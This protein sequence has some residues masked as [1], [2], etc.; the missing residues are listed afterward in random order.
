M[1]DAVILHGRGIKGS[2][3]AEHFRL[4]LDATQIPF[5]EDRPLLIEV[6]FKGGR[7]LKH[8]GHVRD[9]TDI[10]SL[11]ILLKHGGIL[12]HGSHISNLGDIPI[13]NGAIEVSREGKHVRHVRD[14]LGIPQ[15]EGLM[16]GMGT[17]KHVR[18][19]LH[20]MD[21]PPVQGLIKGFGDSEHARH[22]GD[23]GDIP[24]FQRRIEG[25]GTI[26][27]GRHILHA[28]DVPTAQILIELKGRM[29]HARQRRGLADIPATN[30]GIE[31]SIVG[32]GMR[33]VGDFGHAPRANGP[34]VRMS[35]V[36]VSRGIVHVLGHG[37]MQFVG[38][39]EA[40]L[41]GPA[42]IL[43]IQLQMH[44]GFVVSD[45]PRGVIIAFHTILAQQYALSTTTGF[46]L[47]FFTALQG[48]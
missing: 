5:L 35:N 31:L 21:F 10:P 1:S 30:V 7:I 38:I 28:S 36:G 48:L 18:H 41:T 40:S 11:Q 23:A 4:I 46:L 47:F 2:G 17:I 26:E 45:T 27:Q 24:G 6:G 3:K 20:V 29:E 9:L 15:F 37:L 42:V 43:S 19:V 33:K 25:I 16:E 44:R 22:G 8:K 14:Q 12:E 32:K 13:G 39:F 34:P